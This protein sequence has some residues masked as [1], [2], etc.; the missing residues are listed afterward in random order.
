MTT[1]NTL[2][3][4][5]AFLGGTG[6]NALLRYL[7]RNKETNISTEAMLRQEMIDRLDIMSGEIEELKREVSYWRDRYLQLYKEHADLRAHLGLI[8]PSESDKQSN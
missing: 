8:Q 5:I 6:F 3:A 4:I 1:E 7:S 2:A